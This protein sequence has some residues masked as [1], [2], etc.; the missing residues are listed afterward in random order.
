[1]IAIPYLV[2][3][4]VSTILHI[5]KLKKAGIVAGVLCGLYVVYMLWVAGGDIGDSIDYSYVVTI[6][7]MTTGFGTASIFP[8]ILVALTLI[9]LFTYAPI[10]VQRLLV[11]FV[12]EEARKADGERF[13][14]TIGNFLLPSVV[15][16]L[17]FFLIVD[18]S[19]H[20]DSFLEYLAPEGDFVQFSFCGMILAICLLIVVKIIVNLIVDFN[21]T[22]KKK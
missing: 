10:F 15:A 12:N 13:A 1:M 7:G 18:T 6:N 19:A 4:I 9:L 3:L 22:K 8:L 2:L 21:R 11:P 17:P 20:Y 16:F 14:E 5:F